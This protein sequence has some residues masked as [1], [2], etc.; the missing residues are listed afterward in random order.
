MSFRRGKTRIFSSFT[1]G[2]ADGPA[3]VGYV[4]RRIIAHDRTTKMSFVGTAKKKNR[5]RQTRKKR[6][7]HTHTCRR[8]D[9]RG[10]GGDYG[11]GGHGDDDK[12]AANGRRLPRG[13]SRDGGSGYGGGDGCRRRRRRQNY[14]YCYYD[15]RRD[16]YCNSVI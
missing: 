16:E 13:C 5:T 1:T 15:T 12:T 8:R 3:T 7:L 10:G 4:R 6:V 9:G 2:S 11:K 14:Y